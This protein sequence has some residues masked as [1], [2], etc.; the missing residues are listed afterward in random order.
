MKWMPKGYGGERR[1][2]E[3]IKRDGWYEHGILVV[4][5]HDH[6]LTWPERTDPA[7]WR[8]ALRQTLGA[9]GGVPWLIGRRPVSKSACTKR[10]T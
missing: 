1:A 8:K 4:S 6:R 3:G 5:E 9:Q 7:T 2:P 10:P